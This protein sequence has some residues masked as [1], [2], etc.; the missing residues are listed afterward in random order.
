MKSASSYLVLLL[1][2]TT[3]G[4]AVFSWKQYQELVALRAAALSPDD[5][6]NLQKRLW[7]AEK[8]SKAL[9]AE[10]AAARAHPADAAAGEETIVAEGDGPRAAGN[11]ARRENRRGP[12]GPFGG[13]AAMMENPEVQK[14]MA[15]QQRGM[16]DSSYALLF[17]NLNLTPEQLD[18]FKNLLVE[19]QMAMMDVMA[20]AR[21]E[22]IN[23]RTDPDGFRKMIAAAQADIDTSI[24]ATLGDTGFNQYQQYQQTFPQRNT[25][26]QLQQSLSYTN[27]PLSDV[28]A[29]Q[30]VQVLA[31]SSSTTKTGNT[32]RNFTNFMGP[33]GMA[34]GG[35]GGGAP[36]TTEDITQAQGLLSA[37]QV[38]A[39]QQLQQQQ[40]A[41]QQLQQT[42]R[43]NMGGGNRGNDGGATK[44]APK[45]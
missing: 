37:P 7:D 17:K 30:L 31:Q 15:M 10:L 38:Q 44:S 19:K 22:G 29:N 13:F 9:A 18:K 34:M 11:A 3:V 2:L 42:M 39:L 4:G 1:A 28:Q 12:N 27:T 8:R 36:V 5:R 45:N 43:Q 16:L 6:A 24:K 33:G 20:A 32:N 26:N 41:Q 40:Q 21:T 35:S 25:V 23:P 14:L